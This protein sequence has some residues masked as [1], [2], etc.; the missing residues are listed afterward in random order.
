MHATEGL[1]IPQYME[2]SEARFLEKSA[3]CFA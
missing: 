3:A 2:T 1:L